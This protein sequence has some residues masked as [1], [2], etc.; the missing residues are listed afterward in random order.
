MTNPAFTTEGGWAPPWLEWLLNELGEREIVGAKDNPRIVYYHGFTAA[1]TAPDE[2]AWCSS[3]QC[4]AFENFGIRSTRSKAAASWAT[5]GVASAL[6]LGAVGLFGK[7][8][9]DAKGTGHVFNVCGW[10]A[11]YVLGIG[12]NQGNQ[13]SVARRERSALVAVRWPKGFVWP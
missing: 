8:D 2:V 5:W 11:R 6:R 3:V 1:G 12:G 13:M 7:A 9:P 4:A 10:N